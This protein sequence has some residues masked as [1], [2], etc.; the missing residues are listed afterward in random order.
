MYRPSSRVTS[1]DFFSSQ[2]HVR[3]P[4]LE[5]FQLLPRNDV[6]AVSKGFRDNNTSGIAWKQLGCFE[7]YNDKSY[8]N[9]VA[10]GDPQTT[11]NTSFVVCKVSA[12]FKPTRWT[13][14]YI[15]TWHRSIFTAK[16]KNWKCPTCPAAAPL[17]DMRLPVPRPT[18]RTTCTLML[19]AK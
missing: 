6:H 19:T 14:Y 16:R 12:A 10:D 13:H 8:H 18:L 9:L 11:C 2:I 1:E 3:N 4:N 17:A 15:P 5:S 7:L